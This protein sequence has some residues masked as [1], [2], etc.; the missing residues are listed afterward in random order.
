MESITESIKELAQTALGNIKKMQKLNLIKVY[1]TGGGVAQ[2]PTNSARD[3]YIPAFGTDEF[4][5]MAKSIRANISGVPSTPLQSGGGGQDARVWL[6]TREDAIGGQLGCADA[7]AQHLGVKRCINQ[8]RA[9]C[10]LIGGGGSELPKHQQVGG[11]SELPK[12][13]QV[14]GVPSFGRGRGNGRGRGRG[15]NG[16]GRGAGGPPMNPEERERQRLVKEAQQYRETKLKDYINAPDMNLRGLFANT[17]ESPVDLGDVYKLSLAERIMIALYFAYHTQLGIYDSDPSGTS[18]NY[19]LKYS[20]LK[21]SLKDSS[22]Q[23]TLKFRPNF[24]IYN[25]FAISDMGNKLSIVSQMPQSVLDKF[26]AAKTK[27]IP[28]AKRGSY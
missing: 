15:A 2:F 27:I 21:G 17:A 12:H 9:N 10:P 16:R 8:L 6:N 11:G 7:M 1:Q 3:M 24:V 26:K 20:P 28:V 23:E 13:Q 22:L 19:Y 18:N 4:S 14:G 25:T 5:E